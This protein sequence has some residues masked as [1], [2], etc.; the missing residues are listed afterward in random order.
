[1][2]GARNGMWRGGPAL[3]YG[4]GWKAIKQ[5]VRDR[6]GVCRNCGK[7]SEENGRALD[8]HHI[9]PFRF[10]GDHSPENLVALCRRCHMRA[11]DHGRKGSAVFLAKAGRPKPPTRRELRK[12]E[13][14]ERERRRTE[15]RAYL[16][17]YAFRLHG[18]GRSLREIARAV[19]VSHQTVANWLSD[20]P[21]RLVS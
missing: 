9:E 8:V 2:T 3:S 6:D 13:A 1:L 16:Q 21:E 17:R 10:S 15:Q 5:A 11:D 19:G 14:A 12:R 4:A 18:L 20:P 7:T